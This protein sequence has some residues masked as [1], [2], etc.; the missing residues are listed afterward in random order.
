MKPTPIDSKNAGLR[1]ERF[2]LSLL[3]Q[4]GELSQAQLCD[5]AELSSSTASYIVGR[6]REKGLITEKR[7]ESV[8]RGA[9]PVIVS[10]HPRGQLVA[11][12]EVSLHGVCIGLFDFHCE[13]IESIRVPIGEDHSPRAVANLIEIN[14]RGLLGKHRVDEEKLV[15]IGVTMSG[16]MTTDGV[17][18]RSKSMGWKDV[19]FREMLQKRFRTPIRVYT[20]RVRVFAE[21]SRL[22]TVAAK[23]LVHLNFGDSVGASMSVDGQLV[24]GANNRAGE[25]AHAVLDPNGPECTCGQRGCI[26]A[27]ASGP[28]LVARIKADLAN[29][30]QSILSQMIAPDDAPE[31]IFG[32]LCEAT[33]QNDEYSL[34]FREY[35]AEQIGRV[36]G[37]TVN[38]FDPD[39]VVLDGYV[40]TQCPDH[41]IKSINQRFTADLRNGYTREVTIVPA[42]S[43]DQAL[44]RG[45]ATAVLRNSMENL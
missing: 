41:L 2:V 28:A 3:A 42:R 43:G 6:L 16:T 15:G 44:V 23:N 17:I 21:I 1:N 4:H 13:P 24:L 36:V 29:G 30:T 22:P 14:L 27:L 39:V 34:G 45:V 25:I 37:L 19:P 8:K 5:L 26:E 18:L 35:L 31:T 32:H 7:G 10:I 40:C 9:K 33:Q 12:V 20:T 11:G 38:C